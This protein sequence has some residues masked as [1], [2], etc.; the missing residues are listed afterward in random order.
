MGIVVVV[1]EVAGMAVAEVQ[2]AEAIPEDLLE[3]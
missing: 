3:R 1:V 2:V